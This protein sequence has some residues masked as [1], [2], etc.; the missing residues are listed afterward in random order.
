MDNPLR[1]VLISADE[2]ACGCQLSWQMMRDPREE[3]S[4]SVTYVSTAAER[5]TTHGG[6]MRRSLPALGLDVVHMGMLPG[7]DGS[8]DLADVDAIL[9]D[10]VADIHI[11][12]SD[13]VSQRNVLNAGQGD[14]AIVVE[15]QAGQ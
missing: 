7:L 9:D 2:R 14:H 3:R 5:A 15:D 11:L 8:A 6:R 13:L 10:G 4:V 1:K 12:E